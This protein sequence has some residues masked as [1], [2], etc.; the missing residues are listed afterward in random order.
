V[1]FVID[2]GDNGGG[3]LARD[4]FARLFPG[5]R[6]TRGK[7]L[8]FTGLRSSP[9]GRAPLL[10]IG[11]LSYGGLVFDSAGSSSLGL[12][13]VRRSSVIFDFPRETLYLKPGRLIGAEEAADM[14]GLHL[15]R[16]AGRIVALAIDA[17]SPAEQAGMLK[18][19]VILGAAGRPET[20]RDLVE[21]RRLL[22]SGSGN[23]VT[24]DVL[25]DG[26]PVP[27]ELRLRKLL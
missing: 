23:R 13:I 1:T 15:L 12:T 19:D 18:G 20:R 6:S 7:S 27:V 3:N 14:S 5:Q 2:T 25:R 16:L 11:E 26:R 24:L 22:R 4:L 21:L 10:S 17:G 9:S 8:L